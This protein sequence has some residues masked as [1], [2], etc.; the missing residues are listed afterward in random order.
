MCSSAVFKAVYP[1][2]N[3]DTNA[4]PV[5]EIGPAVAFYETVLGF[6][7]VSRDATAAVLERNAVQS[8]LI[9]KDDHQPHQ[10]GSICFT[11]SDIVSLRTELEASGGNPGEFGIDEWD[12]GKHRT[13]FLREDGNGYCFCFSQA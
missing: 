2:A 10:A 6:A 5:K 7:R 8:G 11:V 13:F 3:E 1:I 4:L 9:R 12:G